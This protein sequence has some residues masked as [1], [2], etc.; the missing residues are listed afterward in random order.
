MFL[1]KIAT[2]ADYRR[3]SFYVAADGLLPQVVRGRAGPVYCP[4]N[5]IPTWCECVSPL[6]EQRDRHLRRA[7]PRYACLTYG[8]GHVRGDCP[9]E[10]S[11]GPDPCGC[12]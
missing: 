11:A 9:Q 5:D 6:K 4:R 3:A 2:G 8:F 12:Q 1:P 10:F 7:P